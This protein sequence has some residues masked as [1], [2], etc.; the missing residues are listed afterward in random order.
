VR[1]MDSHQPGRRGRARSRLQRTVA[2]LAVLP[3]VIAASA[4]PLQAQEAVSCE[5][6]D[7][8]HRLDIAVSGDYASLDWVV[9]WT[10]G[11]NQVRNQVL[12]KVND[13]GTTNRDG[14]V[15]GD[16]QKIQPVL[17]ESVEVSDDGLT[18]TFHL[19]QDARHY[20]SGNPVTAADFMWF[21]ERY[22]ALGVTLAEQVLAGIAE[23][24][25]PL[26]GFEQ[27]DDHTF[28]ITASHWTPVLRPIL[29]Y[30]LLPD[31]QAYLENATDDDEWATEWAGNNMA[32]AG[33]YALDVRVPGDRSEFVANPFFPDQPYFT[34]VVQRVVAS[35]DTRALLLRDGAVDMALDLTPDQ[36]NAMADDP[37]IKVVSTPQGDLLGLMM[38]NE[39]EPFNDLRV[40]QAV[41]YMVP[42]NDIIDTVFHGLATELQSPVPGM[43]PGSDYSA[44]PYDVSEE[45]AITKATALLEEAGYPDGIDF[46][47]SYDVGRGGFEQV[48][49]LIQSNAAKAGIN[50]TLQGL[51]PTAFLESVT[52]ATLPAALDSIFPFVPE[53]GYFLNLLY[54]CD[55]VLA[56]RINYCNPQVDSMVSEASRTRDEGERNALYVQ[57]A[58]A[59]LADAPWAYIAARNGNAVTRSDIT[60]YVHY[61]DGL[62]RWEQLSREE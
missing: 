56:G 41:S 42:Y 36:I 37:G 62:I 59:V 19:R 3:L 51:P 31:S 18:H 17:A 9:G 44:W 55:A 23:P 38:N 30:H 43:V 46:T 27:I 32:G 6:V 5:D 16:A 21:E 11:V 54:D 58:E 20:P 57:A 47:L 29:N 33:P 13:Y 39:L 1:T 45:E 50:I 34:C 28:R 52:A 49:T 10:A 7:E 12:G 25:Q 24:D 35:A 22:P 48:A 15:V 2:L 26:A 14:L 4:S 61:P 53:P 60:G 40:R 8:Q